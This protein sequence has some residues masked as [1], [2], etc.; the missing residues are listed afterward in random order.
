MLTTPDLSI[1]DWNYFIE[2][3]CETV[4]EINKEETRMTMTKLSEEGHYMYHQQ[5]RPGIPLVSNRS[6]IAEKYPIVDAGKDGIYM[7]ISS[8]N[9]EAMHKKHADRMG[10]DVIAEIIVNMWH[11]KPTE[12]GKGT[13]IEHISSMNPNGSIPNMLIKQMAKKQGDAALQIANFLRARK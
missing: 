4:I 3:F 9:Q 2:N 1:T 11:W 6:L 12:D 7:V 13:I 5:M 10:K 8:S